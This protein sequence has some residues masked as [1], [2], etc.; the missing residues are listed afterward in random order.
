MPSRR[1]WP[2]PCGGAS[3]RGPRRSDPAPGRARAPRT[4]RRP[5]RTSPATIR[6][7]TGSAVRSER[8]SSSW[9]GRCSSERASNPRRSGATARRSAPAPASMGS[10][11]TRATP[12]RSM[13]IASA[14]PRDRSM[15]RSGLN[16][17]RSVIRTS[18]LRPLVTFV[19][20][21][22]VPNGSVRWAAVNWAGSNT[23][24]LAVRRPANPGPYHDARPSKAVRLGNRTAAPMEA[25]TAPGAGAAPI[26]LAGAQATT[27]S[28]TA[29]PKI[30]T[31][32][33]ADGR[34][35]TIGPGCHPG[36][37]PT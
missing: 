20:R 17:P 18:T 6:T 10:T 11:R 29:T 13:S 31:R 26:P 7:T 12:E 35:R 4:G 3:R 32:T 30:A 1:A 14:A 24:P 25:S 22:R 15:M 2:P 21:T 34:G 27:A 36:R 9:P 16:G 37:L 23:S 5:S 8:S 33:I 19:T 28:A